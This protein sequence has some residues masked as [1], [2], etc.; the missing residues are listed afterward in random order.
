MPYKIVYTTFAKANVKGLPANDRARLLDVVDARLT[1][2]AEVE[3]TNRKRMRDNEY[4]IQWELRVGDL[5]AF[6]NIEG[7]TVNI[8]YIGVKRGNKVYVEGKELKI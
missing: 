6:Y 8:L 3:D 5:R 2:Q 4:G 1:H 7:S